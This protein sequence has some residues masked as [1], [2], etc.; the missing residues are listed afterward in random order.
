MG[1]GCW[2]FDLMAN[3]HQGWHI[4]DA[5]TGQWPPLSELDAAIYQAFRETASRGGRVAV[6]VPRVVTGASLGPLIYACLNLF[7]QQYPDRIRGL[8]DFLPFPRPQRVWPIYLATRS[9]AIRQ[10]W[11]NSLLSFGG[12]EIPFATFRTQ[13]LARNGEL[14]QDVY[15]L[16][17]EKRRSTID[18]LIKGL[19]D[20]ILYDYWPLA[21]HPSRAFG[22]L[23]E[24]TAIDSPTTVQRLLDLIKASRSQWAFV[25]LNLHDIEKRQALSKVGFD[26]IV[27]QTGSKVPELHRASRLLPSF[28]AIHQATPKQTSVKW[29]SLSQQDALSQAL[30]IAFG[31]LSQLHRRLSNTAEYPAALNR[32]WYLFNH[33]STCPVTLSSY[34]KVRR[35][36]PREKTLGFGLNKLEPER[37]NW[38]RVPESARGLLQLHLPY[39]VGHLQNAYECLGNNN[40]LWWS[41]AELVVDATE[42]VTLLMPS[43]LMAQALREELMLEF[44]WSERESPVTI[45]SLSEAHRLNARPDRIVWPGTW[46]NWQ[47]PL[48]WGLLAEEIQI[49]GYPH[50]ALVLRQNLH[51]IEQDLAEVFIKNSPYTDM[52]SDALQSL[53]VVWDELALKQSCRETRRYWQH[54]DMADEQTEWSEDYEGVFYDE[55]SDDAVFEKATE[56]MEQHAVYSDVEDE[57]Q[58]IRTVRI[59]FDDDTVLLSRAEREFIVLPK[60]KRETEQRMATELRAGDK[61]LV[62]SASEQEDVFS[63]ALERTRH[64]LDIDERVLDYWKQVLS[65]L[66]VHYPADEWGMMAQFCDALAQLGCQ[67]DPVTMRSWL[68]GSTMAPRDVKDI[69]FVLQLSGNDADAEAWA[70]FIEREMKQVRAFHQRIGRRIFQRMSGGGSSNDLV[71][72]E[73]DELLEDS[74]LRVVAHVS[75]PSNNPKTQIATNVERATY[76]AF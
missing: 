42:P 9:H 56:Y 4:Q 24:L 20:I 6:G 31:E 60:G 13:R 37:I 50:H 48:L 63:L 67:R 46:A 68:K 15:S 11:A 28:T 45:T 30:S 16:L 33:I 10:L 73:I 21:N 27:C 65:R 69:A 64:L 43:R 34:E 7:V 66:R 22:V 61:V 49:I 52:S 3:P 26:F 19:P 14:K 57:D 72:A 38:Q 74:E 53:K 59:V 40:P 62:F 8:K 41:L 12:M 17:A 36:D 2:T 5:G 58:G 44:R 75:D 25:I 51:K 70:L 47:R 23:A 54:K 76:N 18:H 39:V 32:S 35:Q 55:D 29:T 71:D 1:R